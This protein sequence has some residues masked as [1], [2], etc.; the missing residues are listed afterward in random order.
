MAS[1]QFED[2]L[3]TDL[4][5][6]IRDT[7]MVDTHEHLE[8]EGSYTGDPPDVLQNLFH[9][10]MHDDLMSAGATTDDILFLQDKSN[11]DIAARFGRIEGF[12]QSAKFTGYAEA[13]RLTAR[14]VFGIEEMTAKALED[15]QGINE[16]INRPGERRRLMQEV[17]NLD[18]T[19]TDHFDRHTPAEALGQ[20]F[21]LYDISAT[22]FSDGAP[23]I[24]NLLNE[25]GIEVAGLDSLREV[26][27]TIFDQNACRAAAVKS[28]HAYNRTLRWRARS[29]DEAEVAL[30]SWLAKGLETTIE[31]RLCLGDWCIGQFAE[32]C[33]R[34]DLPFKVHTG[35]YAGSGHMVTD[36]IKPGHLCA[37]LRAHP[38]TRFVLMHIGYPYQ[39]ELLALTK[40]FPNAYVDL[41]WAWAI[42][43]LSTASFVRAHIHSAPINKLLVFGGDTRFPAAVVGFAAQARIW[44]NRSLAQE[45]H[46]GLLSESEAI[47]IAKRF[48]RE[49][50]YTL[51]DLER[52]KA[53]NMAATPD[54]LKGRPGL[55]ERLTFNG[56]V[57]QLA[58]N[59]TEIWDA[60]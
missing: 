39:N 11:P 17:A 60:S 48:M 42:N 22:R 30:A 50:Q 41:C 54:V 44:L 26:I 33:A 8:F 35:F 40:H 4:G 34:M 36:R 13:T 24:E 14:Q 45:I 27:R 6:A 20:E 25:T 58:E 12:W 15:A 2:L 49:N 57:W 52:K 19:Q 46:N 51:F 9:F 23:D 53:A 3:R 16:A 56:S 31:D 59:I 29:D 28:Q 32:N 21:F 37:L 18:S 7:P 47:G 10:Y 38:E 55:E 5:C 1:C 43:P